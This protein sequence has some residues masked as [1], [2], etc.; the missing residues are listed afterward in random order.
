MAER[1]SQELTFSCLAQFEEREQK[2]TYFRLLKGNKYDLVYLTQGLCCHNLLLVQVFWKQQ[3]F[4]WIRPASRLLLISHSLEGLT[5]Y[6][7]YLSPRR[8]PFSRLIKPEHQ[9]AVGSSMALSSC[10]PSPRKTATVL[11]RVPLPKRGEEDLTL[12]W[13]CVYKVITHPRKLFSPFVCFCST[14]KVVV[15]ATSS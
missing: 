12:G 15:H 4:L 14:P 10:W 13:T 3:A 5:N 1:G 8:L 2:A 11:K 9:T 6:H 7:L